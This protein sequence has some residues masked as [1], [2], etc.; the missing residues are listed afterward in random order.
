MSILLLV[1]VYLIF[2]SLGLPDS[3]IGSSWPSISNNLGVGESLQGVITLIISFGTI[4][5]TFANGFLIKKLKP[6]GVVSLS[7][8]LTI[9]GLV[10][11]GLA[12]NFVYICLAAIPLGLGAGA[13]DSTL[14]NFVA[15]H[16]K[17]LHLNWL[18]A[19]WG[20]GALI[21]PLISGGFIASSNNGYK[22]AAFVLAAIQGVICLI[23][24]LAFP[25]WKKVIIEF[26][27][28]EPVNSEKLKNIGFLKTFQIKGVVFAIIAFYSYIAIEQTSSLWF[29]SLVH[30]GY[31]V[32]E[33]L[34]ASWTTL[35]YVGITVG[36]FLSGILSLKIKDKNMIR[37]GEGILI[38]GI[39]FLSFGFNIYLLPVGL[40]LIGLGCAPVYPGIIHATPNRF[41]KELSQNVMNVQIG[42]AYIANVSAAPLFGIIG[43]YI[44]FKVMP[45]YLGIFYILLIL[46]NEIVLKKTIDKT[47]LLE[48]IKI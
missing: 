35:F 45:I 5:S 47:T 26:D 3:F 46:G 33:A 44:D 14:N 25:I 29:S 41:T 39:I 4:V 27:K 2:V 24:F 9:I 36:R 22:I 13:I 6:Y 10:S 18:H 1:I 43:Q 11:I 7:I 12:S 38:F 34:S 16:Y 21:S 8:L 31:G 20:V 15:L 40:T 42:C 30:Y 19:S 23:S 28:K 37:I 17:A 32:S 48:K